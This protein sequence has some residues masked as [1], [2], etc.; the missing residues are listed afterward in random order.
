MKDISNIRIKKKLLAVFLLITF[1]FC[2]LLGRLM[3]VEVFMSRDLQMKA[4]DQ[5]TREL[6]L[7]AKRGVI[8]DRNGVVLADSKT[9]YTMYIRPNSLK[10]HEE[11]ARITSEVLSLSYDSVYAKVTKKG[12]SEIKIATDIERNEMLKIKSYDFDGVF[13]ATKSKR[14]YPYGNFLTQLLGFTNVDGNGQ[15]GFEQYYDNYLSGI[16]GKL[17]NETDL[18]GKKLS[19]SSDRYLPAINGLD[20]TLTIDFEIQGYAEGAVRDAMNRYDAKSA[21]C[22]IMNPKTGELL[23]YAQAPSFNLNDIPRDDLDSLFANSK[24]NMV[25]TVY[26]PGSTFKILTS[27][28]GLEEN[29]FPSNHSFYCPGYRVIDNQRIK[30]WRSIGHGSQS[31]PEGIANSC[32]CVFMDIAGKVGTATM[33]DY[34]DKFGLNKKTGIDIKGETSGLFIKESTVKNVDIA[35]IGF[36]QAVAVTPIGLISAV[37]SVI[38][39]G[40]KI[41]PHVLKSVTGLD[42][43]SIVTTSN[44]MGERIISEKT[45]ATMREYLEGVVSHGGGSHAYVSGYR[46]GGKTGTA[47]K[48]EDG[49][50]ASGKYI[51]SFLGFAP[52]D[53][54]EYVMLMIV[55]E[56]KG[57]VYYGS[58]VAAPY[59]GSIFKNIFAYK[60][61]EPNYTN[62]ELAEQ[63]KT[64]TMPDL[65]GMGIVE[66]VNELKRLG[67]NYEY[68][69]EGG[70]VI[71]QFPAPM[72]EINSKTVTFFELG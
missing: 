50:I 27:A 30:C 59:A 5:W 22:I 18:I 41:T 17:Y 55:D 19:G 61:I 52:V 53:D 1:L 35:R 33:Y 63:G 28:I 36:G 32:N 71:Y 24:P 9:V 15:S 67:L 4:F 46:I 21:S 38:N 3:F 16:D 20:T 23:A 12:S 26:E 6:P 25:S 44:D 64:L 37:S 57:Y 54:P 51:S 56:P 65:R 60:N 10:A 48:Y 13:F 31:F 34:F 49:K 68:S 40:Y 47:Q 14:Y 72:A 62:E 42:G 43:N 2:I 39:G 69:G 70:K 8:T 45:S 11:V 58:L 7:G 29:A 66:A